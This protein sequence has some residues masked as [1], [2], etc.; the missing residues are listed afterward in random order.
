[1]NSLSD[2]ASINKSMV[3]ILFFYVSEKIFGNVSRLI[4]GRPRRLPE[5]VPVRG[6]R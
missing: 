6:E 5:V 1:M 2:N 3:W 4:R